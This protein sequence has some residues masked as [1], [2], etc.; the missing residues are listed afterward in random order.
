VCALCLL[1]TRA[2]GAKPTNQRLPTSIRATAFDKSVRSR[3]VTAGHGFFD[4]QLGQQ[5]RALA[6]G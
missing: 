3:R 5:V 2:R 4:L 1:P 6:F